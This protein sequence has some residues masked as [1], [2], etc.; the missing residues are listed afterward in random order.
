MRTIHAPDAHLKHILNVYKVYNPKEYVLYNKAL[1]ICV[2][3]IKMNKL[4]NLLFYLFFIIFV[5]YTYICC[6]CFKYYKLQFEL[7]NLINN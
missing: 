6:N 1:N 5:I 4:P 2:E 3:L 7:Y